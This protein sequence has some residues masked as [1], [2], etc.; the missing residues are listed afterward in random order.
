MKALYLPFRKRFLR[1]D[2]SWGLVGKDSDGADFGVGVGPAVEVA[3][4]RLREWVIDS[5]IAAAA[6]G[7][8]DSV[9][10]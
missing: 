2:S 9:I 10:C 8:P 5:L 7:G 6:D 1:E 3:E 4:Q